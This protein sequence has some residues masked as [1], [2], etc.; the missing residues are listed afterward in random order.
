MN[1]GVH[2]LS[3][4]DVLG[5]DPDPKKMVEPLCEFRGRLSASGSDQWWDHD[6]TQES[7]I[8]AARSAAEM[9]LQCGRPTLNVLAGE[10]SPLETT[11]AANFDRGDFNFLGVGSTAARMA[12]SLAR[13]RKAQGN[14]SESRAFARIGLTR[15]GNAQ[16][17]RS[18]FDELCTQ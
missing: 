17:L 1:F 7:M 12:L 9:Y 10:V 14:L 4:P 15:I 13:L 3:I 16:G 18:D 8:L 6:G 5:H 11:T 2:P